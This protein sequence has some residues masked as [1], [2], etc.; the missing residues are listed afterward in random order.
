WNTGGPIERGT[1]PEPLADMFV[2]AHE[3][4]ARDPDDTD[5]FDHHDNYYSLKLA[6]SEAFPT[7]FRSPRQPTKEDEDSD[8]NEYGKYAFY[9]GADLHVSVRGVV[10]WVVS[11]GVCFKHQVVVNA[12]DDN[13]PSTLIL[14]AT[15]NERDSRDPDRGIWLKGGLEINDGVH[16]YL[17]SPGDISVVHHYDEGK[18]HDARTVSIVAGGRIE[19][20]GPDSGETFRLGYDPSSMDALADQLLAMSA[21]PQ[22][23]GGAGTSF[24]VARQT[25]VE[26]TPR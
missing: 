26:T 4:G 19:I 2:A 21:L 17:V 10:V 3:P 11:Q 5:D 12:A 22:V 18:S 9:V 16:V 7:F 25:W 14:V 8:K 15:K 20:G 6:G 24:A 1:P 13:V 23:A